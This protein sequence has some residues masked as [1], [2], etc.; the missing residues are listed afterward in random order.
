MQDN[1]LHGRFLAEL[2]REVMN[3][4]EASKYQHAEYRISIYGRKRVEWDI[5]AAW[6]VQN[7]LNSDN[8]IWLIQVSAFRASLECGRLGV[9]KPCNPTP[10]LVFINKRS[11][12]VRSSRGL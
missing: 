6:V 12:T 3:D 11:R 4:L 2:T 7:K 1:L 9:S 10:E 8:V 5:L